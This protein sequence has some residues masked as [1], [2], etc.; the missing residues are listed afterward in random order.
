M[1]DGQQNIEEEKINQYQRSENENIGDIND[2]ASSQ[3]KNGVAGMWQ[4]RRNQ[5]SKRHG[6][7]EGEIF[8][9]LA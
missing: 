7:G 1:H 5:N 2:A 9:V 8:G 3:R 4:R 6:S